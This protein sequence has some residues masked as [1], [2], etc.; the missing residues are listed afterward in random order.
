MPTDGVCPATAWGCTPKQSPNK[1]LFSGIE[2]K[3]RIAI[4]EKTSMS[5]EAM[6]HNTI[7]IPKG[8]PYCSHHARG[9]AIKE[10]QTINRPSSTLQNNWP[11]TTRMK[12]SY[13]FHFTKYHG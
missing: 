8:D 9:N 10:T 12:P 4:I 7:R 13:P 2:E 11:H 6:Q 5:S 3:A 1:E